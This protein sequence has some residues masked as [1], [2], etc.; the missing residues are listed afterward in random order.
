MVDRCAGF[1]WVFHSFHHS[2]G[3][4][5]GSTISRLLFLTRS[6]PKEI[7]N[8]FLILLAVDGDNEAGRIVSDLAHVLI[9]WVAL[10]LTLKRL[11]HRL[12]LLGPLVASR[13]QPHLDI[14][15]SRVQNDRHAIM[16]ELKLLV[17]VRRDD[18]VRIQ[19]LTLLG[20]FIPN[21]IPQPSETH[22]LAVLALDEMRDLV[23]GSGSLFQPFVE[24]LCDH[25]AAFLRFHRRPHALVLEQ[26]VVTAVDRAQHARVVW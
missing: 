2:G 19:L 13:V 22:Q 24:A 21:A 3:R 1:F 11:Q 8:V 14:L 16:Q 17:R 18:R 7:G 12:Q 25:E 23:S 9:D 4:S 20:P 6:I 5:L 10:E 26:A 15:G